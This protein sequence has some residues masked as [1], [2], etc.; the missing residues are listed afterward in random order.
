MMEAIVGKIGTFPDAHS[1]VA[2][3]HQDI[4]G[5]IIAAEQFLLNQLILLGC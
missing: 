3:Q 5:Q 1:G 2:H 4:G